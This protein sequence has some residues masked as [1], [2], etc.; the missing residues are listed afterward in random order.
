ME[1]PNRP[2]SGQPQPGPPGPETPQPGQVPPPP[3][4][5]RGPPP[6]AQTGQPPLSIISLVTGILGLL[7]F[8]C[9]IGWPA[10][11]AAVVTGILGRKQAPERGASPTMATIGLV[12]GIIGI[13][14]AIGWTVIVGFSGGFNADFDT[15]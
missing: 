7:T 4:A 8:W 11:I 2:Q 5:G 1:D 3:Q 15:S 12:L 9:C 13:V 6:P 10:S 14:L